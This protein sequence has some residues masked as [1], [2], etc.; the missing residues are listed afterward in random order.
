MSPI[1][2]LIFLELVLT[3][4]DCYTQQLTATCYRKAEGY[5]TNYVD[6]ITILVTSMDKRTR[7]DNLTNLVVSYFKQTVTEHGIILTDEKEDSL[8][9]RKGKRAFKTVKILGI[10]IDN[11]L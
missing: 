6:N 4:M 9:C 3:E 8:T 1:L 2:F 11:T 7:V 5:P 10:I